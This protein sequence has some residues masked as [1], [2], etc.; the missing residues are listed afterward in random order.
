M[1]NRAKRPIIYAGG[2]IMNGEGAEVLRR[3]AR[4]ASIPVALTLRG[5]GCFPPV[6]P[7]Y[8][9]MLGMHGAPHTNYIL[10]EADLLLAFGVR[11]DDRA[12]GRV[13]E[14]CPRAA[15][16]HV[17][18]D[19]SEIHKI[20][21]AHLPLVA[22]VTAVM[23]SLAPLVDGNDRADWT[24]RIETLRNAHPFPS[25]RSDDP[26]HPLNIIETVAGAADPEAIIT[27]DVGQHQMW[28]AQAYPFHRPRTL[29]T[30]SGLGTMGFGLPA[31]IGAALANPCRQVI[32]FSGDGSIQM[33]IQ[34]L[35]TL[36]ELDLPVS[37]VIM[38][39]QHLGL[40][41]QQ[42]ELFFGQTYIASRFTTRLNFAGIGREF[43]IRS[44]DLGREK[45]AG[46]AILRT[47]REG[48]PN[49]I[50]VPIHDE[51]NVFPM[52]PPGAAN[53]EMIMKAR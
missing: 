9:G 50:D 30:S 42:Q 10:D 12:I 31:A 44:V 14:F 37:I 47:L 25:F 36:A 24:A 7:L 52:V 6:D 15:I 3:L 39:N 51:E 4:K 8:L 41:R 20:R 33:N 27:T 48:G 22:D 21:K 46:E 35:A 38:N 1:I 2:G 5:L 26:L 13:E 11:F 34:E 29:L 23:E 18:I 40:V 45:D 32:C 49:I 16:V 43:G 53:R 19:P 17:D 28:V